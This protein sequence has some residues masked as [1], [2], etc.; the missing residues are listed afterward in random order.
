MTTGLGDLGIFFDD[1]VT[2][3]RAG[4]NHEAGP[5]LPDDCLIFYILELLSAASHG[6]QACGLVNDFGLSQQNTTRIDHDELASA[7]RAVEV[8]GR[9]HFSFLDWAGFVVVVPTRRLRPVACGGRR[10]IRGE[11]Y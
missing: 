5:F 9:C 8:N 10:P 2:T 1:R 4:I 11:L 7:V 3:R 6:A